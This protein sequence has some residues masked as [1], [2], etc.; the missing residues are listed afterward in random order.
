MT[1]VALPPTG[2]RSQEAPDP[3]PIHEYE[4]PVYLPD[5]PQQADPAAPAVRLEKYAPAPEEPE[6]PPTGT[7]DQPAPEAEAR[8]QQ[9]RAEAEK[10]A[11]EAER[12]RL[13]N[14]RAAM[15]L[16]AEEA[17]HAAK[18]AKLTAE[19]EAAERAAA[20]EKA[21]AEAAQEQ[22]LE[23][24]EEKAKAE[25]KWKWGALGIYVAGAVV[26]LPLQLLAFYDPEKKFL[27]MAPVFLEGL[28]LVLSFGANAAVSAGKTVWPYRVGVM[29]AAGIAAAVNLV[30]GFDDPKIGVGAGTIGALTSI[31]GPIVWTAYEH[32]RARRLDGVPTRRERIAA[33]RAAAREEAVA[34]MEAER[35]K[36]EEEARAEAK[37]VEETKKEQAATAAAKAAEQ[38]QLRR[39][40]ERE[41]QHPEVWAVAVARR[42]ATGAAA[43][44]E[45][46]WAAAWEVVHGT[47]EVGVTAEI[48]AK[49]LAA[50]AA[51]QEAGKGA[52]ET[53]NA[54]VESQMPRRDPDA[55]DGRRHNGGTPPRRRPGDSPPYVAGVG[56]VSSATTAKRA[57]RRTARSGRR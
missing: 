11:A 24:A 20:E 35:A 6:Q 28:A 56:K 51:M 8:A 45:Q 9:V 14:R 7:P 55:E 12:Q 29:A 38:D 3:D 44:T 32:G 19:R 42:T 47:K 4:P 43:V 17:A 1:T 48:R 34:A 2:L 33:E 27:L 31:G 37:R 16:E 50:R 25:Q 22:V 21:A 40:K 57:S 46:I 13:S 30:H 10:A 26:S 23:E 49:M 53:A 36:A 52:E 5:K 18:M 39:D 54:Q 15:R 41:A